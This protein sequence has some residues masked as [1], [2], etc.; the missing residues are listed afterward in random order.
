MSPKQYVKVKLPECN[1]VQLYF[2]N[3]DMVFAINE[4]KRLKQNNKDELFLA[5]LLKQQE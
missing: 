3:H 5:D 4:Y 1:N 2:A